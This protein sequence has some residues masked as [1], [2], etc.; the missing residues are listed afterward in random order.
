MKRFFLTIMLLLTT[1]QAFSWWGEEEGGEDNFPMELTI[2]FGKQ[3]LEDFILQ[4]VFQERGVPARKLSY[5][6]RM[7]QGSSSFGMTYKCLDENLGVKIKLCFFG[8]NP[9]KP[10]DCFVYKTDNTCYRSNTVWKCKV[11]EYK[12]VYIIGF[13]YTSTKLVIYKP[14][15]S[16]PIATWVVF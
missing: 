14:R 5:V 10:V 15:N 3:N 6:M 4:E 1:T 2:P 7:K 13:E 12:L 16:A 9:E 11:S 8:E